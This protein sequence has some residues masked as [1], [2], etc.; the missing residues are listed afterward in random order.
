MGI[1]QCKLQKKQAEQG[2]QRHKGVIKEHELY[3]V[4]KGESCGEL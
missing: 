2:T 3:K 4:T 1:K